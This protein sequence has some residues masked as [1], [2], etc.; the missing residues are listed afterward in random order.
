MVKLVVLPAPPGYPIIEENPS[1]KAVEKGRNAV[2]QCTATGDPP[3]RIYWLKDFLPVNL[4]DERITLLSRG[5]CA[6]STVE[7][8][9]FFTLDRPILCVKYLVVPYGLKSMKYRDTIILTCCFV[10]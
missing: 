2:L 10:L 4:Q 8:W 3:P 6:L 7:T 9:H 5:Q 1:L